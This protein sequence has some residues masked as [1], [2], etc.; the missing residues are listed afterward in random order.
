MNT[1]LKH[2]KLAIRMDNIGI[3]MENIKENT[4]KEIINC[5]DRIE[6]SE[7]LNDEYKDDILIQREMIR[8]D[9]FLSYYNKLFENNISIDKFKELLE[10]IK[11]DNKKVSDFSIQNIL[12]VLSNDNLRTKAYYDYLKCFCNENNS[13]RDK[14]TNNLNHFHSQDIVKLNKLSSNQ[15]ELFKIMNLD[16]YNLIP[17]E[18]ID[19]IYRYLADNEDLRKIIEFLDFKKLY[20]PLNI[21]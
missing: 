18:N 1:M 16:N 4:L 19:S 14:I 17:I 2:A 3:K 12:E 21:E 6:K 20:I 10:Q 11:E 9:K 7:I 15:I 8:D 5:C 13:I